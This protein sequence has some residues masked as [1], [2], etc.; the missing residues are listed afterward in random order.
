[1]SNTNENNNRNPNKIKVTLRY[2]VRELMVKAKN[3]QGEERQLR[4]NRSWVDMETVVD[5]E[6]QLIFAL[7]GEGLP[8]REYSV[9]LSIDEMKLLRS[10]YD[11]GNKGKYEIVGSKPVDIL[12]MV[13]EKK[14]PVT[15]PVD[16]PIKCV[17]NTA[18]IADKN[19]Q[20]TTEKIAFRSERLVAPKNVDSIEQQVETLKA[21]SKCKNWIQVNY[22]IPVGTY[23]NP[24]PWLWR[25]AF[26]LTESVWMFTD[27]TF[28][29][30]DVQD[31]LEAFNKDYVVT[32]PITGQD[33]IKRVTYDILPQSE[34]ENARI[35]GI[36]INRLDN[37]V[38]RIHTSLIRLLDNAAQNLDKVR[39]DVEKTAKDLESSQASYDQTVRNLLRSS[40]KSLETAI[41]GA[42][43][44]DATEETAHLF[45]ALRAAIQSAAESFNADARMRHAKRAEPFKGL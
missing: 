27:E 21:L 15:A 23:P 1:M 9:E 31:M 6:R 40:A 43:A 11:K 5:A 32:N 4:L 35:R 45:N 25:H 13:P 2:D 12:S 36:A 24:S 18:P 37:E 33:E 10:V 19:I 26:R 29:R 16:E 44:F 39:T 38:R 41:A 20:K 30:K 17:I 7:E 8:N 3:K 28:A 42:E 14:A 22:D 34:S